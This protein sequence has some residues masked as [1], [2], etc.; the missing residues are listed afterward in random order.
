MSKHT[1]QITDDKLYNDIVEFC[2]INNKKI[3]L[4]CQ[5]L[6][7]IQFLIE[8]YGD[9]P[10]GK[11]IHEVTLPPVIPKDKIKLIQPTIDKLVDDYTKNIN[12]KI[13][14]DITKNDI[15]S[16][17]SK[18]DDNNENFI[19]DEEILKKN[20]IEIK[21]EEPKKKNIRRL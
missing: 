8:K 12:N 4:F 11:V 3:N 7:R 10:F 1:I 18:K 6:L 13:I 9:T 14:E 5:E 19:N 16:T 21:V 17:L 15:S 20:T 2:K